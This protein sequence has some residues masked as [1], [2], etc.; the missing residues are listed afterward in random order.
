M[1]CVRGHYYIAIGLFKLVV[2]CRC[3]VGEPA[4]VNPP[5][6]AAWIFFRVDLTTSCAEIHAVV[7]IGR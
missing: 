2:G 7:F 5:H 3:G 4:G 6:G 1:I